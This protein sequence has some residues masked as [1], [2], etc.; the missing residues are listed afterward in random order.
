MVHNPSVTFSVQLTGIVSATGADGPNFLPP[1]NI[2][3]PA[4]PIS[5]AVGD[6]NGDGKPDV[7]VADDS[8]SGGDLKI[9]L[10]TTTTGS[11][12]PTFSMP[13]SYT[14]R[15]TPDYVAIADV[16]GDG[17][18]DVIVVGT[19]ILVFLNTMAIGATTPSFAAP[20]QFTPGIN[21]STNSVAVG[22][23]N[24]DGKP[25]IVTTSYDNVV[26]VLMNT[27]LTRRDGTPSF[28]ARCEQF[29]VQKVNA[30]IGSCGTRAMS[31]AT[32]SSISPSRTSI[33]ET[34]RCC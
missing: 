24:N 2:A 21:A 19:Y 15:S 4:S 27:T 29:A 5:A 34:C 26:S 7:V 10:N 12:R 13:V 18:Q 3:D 1:T 17:K 33:R 31:M 11:T 23:L 14:L 25:D 22:D 6:L 9:F 32:A 28:A 16:N 30:R 20:V 8:N